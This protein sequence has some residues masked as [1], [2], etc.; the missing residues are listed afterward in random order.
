MLYY[1]MYIQKHTNAQ[2]VTYPQAQAH[3]STPV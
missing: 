1:G 3:K 2:S